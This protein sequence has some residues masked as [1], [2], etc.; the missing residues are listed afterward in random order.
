MKPFLLL[1]AV[2]VLA[3]PLQGAKPLQENISKLVSPVTAERRV[4]EAWLTDHGSKS[5]TDLTAQVEKGDWKQ[6]SEAMRTLTLLISPWQRGVETGKRHHG[7]IELFRPNRPTGRPVGHPQ[8]PQLRKVLI[9]TP[10]KALQKIDREPAT[11][12]DYTTYSNLGAVIQA[13]TAALAEVADDETA[14]AIRGLLEKEKDPTLGLSLMH[15]LEAIY[16][17]PAYFHMHGLCGVGLTPEIIRQHKEGEAKAFEAKK[18]E[19]L[20]WLDKHGKQPAAE[21]VD[22]AIAVWVER[23]SENPTYL[24]SRGDGLPILTLA[25]LGDAAVPGLR[26]QQGR[27]TTLKGRAFFEVVAATITGKVDNK[28]VRELIDVKNLNDQNLHQVACEIIA[29]SG[30]QDYQK[31]LEAMLGDPR[32]S[33]LDVAQTLAIV[34]RHAALPVLRKQPKS[35]YIAECAVKELE[36]WPE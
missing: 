19:L 2:M 26:K 14:K 1:A 7:Q 24:V 23:S 17:L 3:V 31:E 36:S 12:K 13:S 8:A 34:H 5:I 35:N 18:K 30:S 21:R 4:G 28:L 20:E 9:D 6:Q 22:A 25:R 33:G 27:E 32:Y 16:G 29:L 11:A 10:T 15:C